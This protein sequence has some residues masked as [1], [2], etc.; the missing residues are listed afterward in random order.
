MNQIISILLPAVLAMYVYQRIN[1]KEMN[2]QECIIKYFTFV[3]IIN[4]ASYLVS[5][6]AFGN[7]EFVFDSVFTVKYL[8]LSSAFGVILSFVISFIEENLDI[9][10]RVDKK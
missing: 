2:N 8:C 7:K 9:N 10:I 6:Y 1:K 3:L 5:V 4:I